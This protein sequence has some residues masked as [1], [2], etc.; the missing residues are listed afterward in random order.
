MAIADVLYACIECGRLEALRPADNG[1]EICSR[2]GT[3][4]RRVPYARIQVEP[5]GKPAEARS[6][7]EW[8]DMLAAASLEDLDPARAEPVIVRIADRRRPHWTRGHYLGRIE[9]FG[10]AI[11]GTLLLE[12]D[13]LVFETADHHRAEWPL[14]DLTAVQP[15]SR[16]LQLKL[17]NGPLVSIR[18]PEGSAVLWEMR[19]QT[20][21]QDLY[22]DLGKGT[23]LEFQPRIVTR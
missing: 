14:L 21:L 11:A 13:R 4:Y 20:A 16:T 1:T 18:F 3:R 5:P 7:G 12:R 8:L 2:C 17:R 22:A 10:P 19:V 9:R 23:I 15:S 6:A